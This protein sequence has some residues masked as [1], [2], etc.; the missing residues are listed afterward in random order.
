MELR[1]EDRDANPGREFGPSVVAVGTFDGV[2]MGHQAILAETRNLAAGLH[3][4]SAV[5][6]FDRHPASVVRPDIA[7]RLLTDLP[8]RIELLADLGIDL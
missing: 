4:K 1:Y 6:I 3:A 8:H 7:P 5:V 2:H